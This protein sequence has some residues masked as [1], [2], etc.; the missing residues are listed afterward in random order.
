[1]ELAKIVGG[2]LSKVL[3]EMSVEANL[4][5]VLRPPIPGLEWISSGYGDFS[6]GDTLI[7]VKCTSKRFS[8]SDYRQVAI[9]WLLSYAAEIEGRGKEWRNFSLVNPRRG[10]RVSMRFD[11][12]L[13]I[14]SSG[15]AKVDIL[16]LFQSL[17]GSR[18]T[19]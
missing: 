8:S 6:L 17:V 4:P 3:K 11:N 19:R 12:F 14:I 13:S 18:L 5:I 9:Y 1:L 7:E 2:N 15:R 16:Q 10:E